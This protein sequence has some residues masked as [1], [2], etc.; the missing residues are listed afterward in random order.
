VLDA[1][2][3]FHLDPVLV[4]PAQLG[5]P[6]LKFCIESEYDEAFYYWQRTIAIT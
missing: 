6:G 2:V 5:L 4:I 1:A 3:A